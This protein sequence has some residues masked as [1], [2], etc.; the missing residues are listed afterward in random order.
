MPLAVFILRSHM[1]RL[2]MSVIESA[3]ID[4]ASHFTTFWRLVVPISVPAFASF[5]VVQFLW[6]WNDLLV[7]LLFL[8][9]GENALATLAW[10]GLHGQDINGRELIPAAAFV[11]ICVPVI[12]LLSL[13]RYLGQGMSQSTDRVPNWTR[14]HMLAARPL[15]LPLVE[16][17]EPAHRGPTSTPQRRCL[18]A[19]RVP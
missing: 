5:A 19:G 15:H 3:R 18:A 1:S 14:D 12:V 17:P 10:Q 4:G 2:P 11:T 8:G 9:R 7:A 16:A 6:V 13:Q